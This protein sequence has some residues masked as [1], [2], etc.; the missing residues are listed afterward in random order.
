MRTSGQREEHIYNYNMD[1]TFKDR[2]EEAPTPEPAELKPLESDE[3]G[4]AKPIKDELS[5]DEKNLTVWEGL[6]HTRF[7]DE[8]FNTKNTGH[9]FVIKMPTSEIDKF[10]KSELKEREQENTID[11]YRR[12]LDEI[13]NEIGTKQM[14][15]FKRFN[16]ITGYIRAMK[17]LRKAKALKESYIQSVE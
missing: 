8:Y 1:N 17:N 7:I 9:E 12:I 4:N 11:N 2:V 14:E 15:L 13:E 6:N 3:I 10:V 5:D 16:K